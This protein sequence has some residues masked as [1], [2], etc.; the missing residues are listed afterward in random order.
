MT[1]ANDSDTQVL[2]GPPDA[3]TDAEPAP[4]R[5][6]RPKGSGRKK[7]TEQGADAPTA[8]PSDA[9]ADP[10]KRRGRRPNRPPEDG[11]FSG[12]DRDDEPSTLR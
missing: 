1:E 9:P 7:E 2:Q 4:R 10:P 5:R 11:L 6:G 8:A 3:A 12:G